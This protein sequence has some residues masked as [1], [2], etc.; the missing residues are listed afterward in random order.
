MNSLELKF[1]RMKKGLSQK[2]MG[3][4]IEKSY[5]SYAKKERG[6]VSFFP[7]EILRA[8]LRLDLDYDHFN[9]IFFDGKL[10]FRK[11]GGVE[12]EILP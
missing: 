11:I 3:D 9:L 10:P 5:D 6:E 2:E 4:A 12:T 1:A 7:D 8:T